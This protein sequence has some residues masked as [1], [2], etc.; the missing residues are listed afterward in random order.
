MY[1]YTGSLNGGNPQYLGEY[2]R[3]NQPGYL[4]AQVKQRCLPYGVT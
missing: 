1:V 4:A 3:T 2:P